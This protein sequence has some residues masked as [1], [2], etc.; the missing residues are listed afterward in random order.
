MRLRPFSCFSRSWLL[1][2]LAALALLA[3]PARGYIFDSYGDGFWTIINQ[4]NGN[5]LVAGPAGASQAVAGTTAAQQQF[6]LLYNLQNASFRIRN[7]ESWLC[8]GALNGGVTNRTPVAKTT[9]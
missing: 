5:T 4:A 3:A 8:I 1:P 9:A 7:R 6:E 2:S